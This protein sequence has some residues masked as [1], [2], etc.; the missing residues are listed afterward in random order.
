MNATETTPITVP[1]TASIGAR[2]D[3]AG[4]GGGYTHSTQYVKQ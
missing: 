3:E 2:G 1:E 4:G